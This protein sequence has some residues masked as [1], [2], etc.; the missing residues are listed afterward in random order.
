MIM[1]DII[2]IIFVTV[3]SFFLSVV[4]VE[5]HYF[6]D[7]IE[8]KEIELKKMKFSCEINIKELTNE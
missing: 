7:C 1:D 6:S 3:L 8:K 5:N 2:L 4:T